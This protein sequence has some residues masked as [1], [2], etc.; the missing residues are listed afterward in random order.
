[1]TLNSTKP[2]DIRPFQTQTKDMLLNERRI[3]IGHK[4]G[5]GKTCCALIALEEIVELNP[6]AKILVSCSKNAMHTWER[7][8]PRV[9]LQGRLPTIIEGD[10]FDR[11]Q[12]WGEAKGF[13]VCTHAALKND[14][15]H[16]N[17]YW[18]IIINDE[19]HRNCRNRK[20]QSF[21]TFK[22]L[23]SEYLALMSGTLFRKGV[24]DTWAYL[25][26][27]DRKKFTSYWQ[28]LAYYTYLETNEW[29]AK[30][31]L[32]MKRSPE[33]KELM[34][35]YYIGFTKKQ[36]A[37][38]LPDK[39]R[40]VVPVKMDS[41]QRK[42]YDQ[43]EKHMLMQLDDGKWLT[44]SGVLGKIVRLR[45]MNVT[46]KLIDPTLP[47]GIVFDTWEESLEANPHCM[48]F[49]PFKRAFPFIKEVADRNKIPIR[50]LSGGASS[51]EIRET[52]EA[53]DRERGI[54][55]STIQFAESWELLTTDICHFLGWEYNPD[56]NE[57]AEDRL[58]RLITTMNIN[59]YYYLVMNSVDDRT[60]EINN[61]KNRAV[62][63]MLEGVSTLNDM[64]LGM[65]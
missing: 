5:L 15:R 11:G 4:M 28:F 48:V 54:L 50:F 25:N 16:I 20:V 49:T 22:G 31:V 32:G 27:I 21:K 10:A 23:E 36:V 56:S 58:H 57:Q 59:Y 62:T 12:L 2:F 19:A 53:V 65:E 8:S 1:M 24:E 52:L 7:E 33:L 6:D 46:P 9:D 35:R 63:G 51:K 3:M 43:F 44:T 17:S 41:I 45:M 61:V 18:D 37:S 29:G 13:A 60:K 39:I 64:I 55:C 30:E 40:Q 26:I 38:E 14:H 42:A 34:K 47:Q